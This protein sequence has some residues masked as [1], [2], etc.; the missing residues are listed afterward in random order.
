[1]QQNEIEEIADRFISTLR[2]E[3]GLPDII[4]ER[5]RKEKPMLVK[6]LEG[7]PSYWLVP[8]AC[9]D[10]LVGFFRLGLR[11]DL[12]AYGRFGQGKELHDFPLLSSLSEETAENEIQKAFGGICDEISSPQFV[13]DGPA[14]RI[15]W[16]SIGKDMNESRILLFWTF[17]FSYSRPEGQ[18]P[19]Y[20]LL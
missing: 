16:L 18:E 13:Q 15:A 10:R 1:M 7:N 11:G 20:G 14:D 9:K 6:D 8:L 17:G 5:T 2:G 19:K 12:L 3:L 4:I